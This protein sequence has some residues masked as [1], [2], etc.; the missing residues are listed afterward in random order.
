MILS[1]SGGI[2]YHARAAFSFPS[3]IETRRPVSTL[4]R[5]W[6]DET[7]P[8]RLLIFGPSSG[9]LLAGDVFGT[10]AQPLELVVVDPDRIAKIIFQK[11][12][13]E[14]PVKW[15]ARSDLLPFTSSDPDAFSRFVEN[16]KNSRR[17]A[18]L[19]CGLFGQLDLHQAAF[20]RSK[21]EAS[22]ILMDAL[23]RLAVP[24]ASLHD[25]ESTF[26]FSRLAK[27]ADAEIFSAAKEFRQLPQ[28]ARIAKV[29]EILRKHT[30]KDDPWIDHE[31]SWL[32]APQA[33]VP[34]MLSR[35]RLHLLGWV[36][37]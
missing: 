26:L 23:Q 20:K 12:F 16:Q 28:E 5:K 1:A 30:A 10:A 29:T 35:R 31:T 3:W 25:L 15:I 33:V 34:W 11:R 22:R 19:F 17:I 14:N 2:V 32:G 24:W 4:V 13:C 37:S 7:K 9:Y 8:E 36:H 21:S 6:L 18:V 27:E